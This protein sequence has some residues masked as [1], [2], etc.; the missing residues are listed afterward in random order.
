MLVMTSIP[1]TMIP[2]LDMITPM[3]TSMVPAVLGRSLP[4]G[5]ASVVLELPMEPKLEVSN[6]TK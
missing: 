1:M 2:F 5:M 6:Q 3:R 4:T